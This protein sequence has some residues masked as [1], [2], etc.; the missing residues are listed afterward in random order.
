MKLEILP[1]GSTDI[2]IGT[3]MSIYHIQLRKDIR[4]VIFSL[5]PPVF[6]LL[7]LNDRMVSRSFS[8]VNWDFSGIIF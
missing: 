5:Y 3:H 1:G 4:A 6:F 2:H 8:S 7:P